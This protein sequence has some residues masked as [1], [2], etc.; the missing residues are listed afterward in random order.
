[1]T[2][3]E[4]L[5]ST[6]RAVAGQ[7]MLDMHD[8]LKQLGRQ[9]KE[10]Q[11]RGASDQETL[12]NLESRQRMQEADVERM[13]ERQDIQERVRMLQASR[14]FAKY[15]GARLKHQDAKARRKDASAELQKLEKEVAPSLRSVND[16]QRYE[17]QLGVVAKERQRAVDRADHMATSIT[18]R[19]AALD[20]QVKELMSQKEAEQ[21]ENRKSKTDSAR[22]EQAIMRLKKQMEEEPVDLDISSYNEQIVSSDCT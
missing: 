21:R 20:D 13:R 9:V 8:E 10:I 3:V 14:P 1:M 15:R 12:T 5:H 18:K 7:E 6:Q 11:A 16:K 4:L 17:E 22:F 2:P 19:I